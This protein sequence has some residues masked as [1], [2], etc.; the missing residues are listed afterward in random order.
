M[1]DDPLD[2]MRERIALCRRLAASTTDR[3]VAAELRRIAEEGEA[4]LARLEA[5]R[6]DM[7]GGTSPIST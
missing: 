1:S 5:E 4:D 2:H 6:R 7:R 3:N